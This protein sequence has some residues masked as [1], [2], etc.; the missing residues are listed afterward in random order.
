MQ[1]Q[2]WDSIFMFLHE[3]FHTISAPGKVMGL[4][5]QWHCTYSGRKVA[6]GLLK[7]LGFITLL[8]VQSLRNYFFQ[9]LLKHF[10]GFT[11]R[12]EKARRPRWGIKDTEMVSGF[13]IFQSKR[14]LMNAY[15]RGGNPELVILTAAAAYQEINPYEFKEEFEGELGGKWWNSFGSVCRESLLWRAGLEKMQHFKGGLCSL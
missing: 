11:T 2:R 14:T 6:L 15:K 4:L 10:W 3:V 9:S 8:C 1:I 7:L 12:T 13:R 5:L